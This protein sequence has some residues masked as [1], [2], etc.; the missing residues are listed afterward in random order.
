MRP[1]EKSK[2]SEITY[3]KKDANIYMSAYDTVLNSLK[4]LDTLY[5][6]TMPRTNDPVIKGKD[7]VNGYTRVIKIAVEHKVDKI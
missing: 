4:K 2:S 1:D 6:P 5:N 3:H 7:E